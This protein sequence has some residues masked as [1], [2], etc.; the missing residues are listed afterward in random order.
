MA[1]KK[2]DLPVQ[3]SLICLVMESGTAKISG[4]RSQL[5]RNDTA[6]SSELHME[7]LLVQVGLLWENRIIESEG[8]CD[9]A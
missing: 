4:G 5:H 8:S 1:G 9:S 6:R 2:V 7:I 3:P